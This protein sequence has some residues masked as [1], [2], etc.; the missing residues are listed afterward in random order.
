MF[1]MTQSL[2]DCS[3]PF[4]DLHL[5]F[6]SFQSTTASLFLVYFFSMTS[7]LLLPFKV[8]HHLALTHLSTLLPKAPKQGAPCLFVSF[9]QLYSE[10]LKLLLDVRLKWFHSYL[11]SQHIILEV[12]TISKMKNQI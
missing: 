5:Y 7:R 9:Q 11:S 2:L 1:N 6:S 12:K 3:H 8:L 4:L 10:S